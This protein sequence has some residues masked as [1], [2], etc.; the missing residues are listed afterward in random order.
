MPFLKTVECGFVAPCKDKKSNPEDTF[1]VKMQICDM[2]KTYQEN[3]IEPIF[4]SLLA[5]HFLNE[6]KKTILYNNN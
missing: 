4:R 6:K 5:R 1:E 2:K 3:I